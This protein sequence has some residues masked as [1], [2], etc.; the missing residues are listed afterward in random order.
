MTYGKTW[1][2]GRAVRHHNLVAA[3][4]PP[5]TGPIDKGKGKSNTAGKGKGRPKSAVLAFEFTGAQSTIALSIP[6]TGRH[7]RLYGELRSARTGVDIATAVFQFNGA[8]AN[9][10][11]EHV[12]GSGATVT[13]TVG[14]SYASISGVQVRL[15]SSTAPAADYGLLDAIIPNY[16]NTTFHK[17]M[18]LKNGQRV[19]PSGGTIES[20]L[21]G[22]GSTAI[23][24][25]LTLGNK[26]QPKRKSI[27]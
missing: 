14:T 8:T 3:T 5:I 9:Y 7:L 19:T 23:T 10:W 21:N 15:P 1:H 22:G 6:Q 26:K 12:R 16:T 11:A 25:A 27:G 18:L 20:Q 4:Q 24:A 2:E 13:A 17:H